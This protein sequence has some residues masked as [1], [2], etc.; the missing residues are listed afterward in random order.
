MAHL[1]QTQILLLALCVAQW[2]V[3]ELKELQSIRRLLIE[4]L[5]FSKDLFGIQFMEREKNYDD[6]IV[7]K[8][9]SIHSDFIPIALEF[10]LI[11]CGS[12]KIRWPRDGFEII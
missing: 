8:L 10:S 9:N 6:K 12:L 2:A 5:F 11:P 7:A 3:T 4:L 1:K